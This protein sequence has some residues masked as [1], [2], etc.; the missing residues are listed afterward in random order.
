[1]SGTSR[2]R[3]SRNERLEEWIDSERG[4]ESG[5]SQGWC[6]PTA[7]SIPNTRCGIE[8]R[9]LLSG[10]MSHWVA[11]RCFTDIGDAVSCYPRAFQIAAI[12]LNLDSLGTL[13]VLSI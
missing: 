6:V 5:S 11:L 10:V 4:G 7:R 13:L 3:V 2:W 8:V 9:W 12:G 1:M